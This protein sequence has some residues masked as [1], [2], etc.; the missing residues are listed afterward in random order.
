MWCP[1]ARSI[2]QERRSVFSP[3][4]STHF[5]AL[6][7][8][9]VYDDRGGYAGGDG[10]PVQ[11]GF[12]SA[13]VFGT[14]ADSHKSGGDVLDA[15]DAHDGS[16]LPGGFEPAGVLK[17]VFESTVGVNLQELRD[18]RGEFASLLDAG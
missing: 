6:P 16:E 2:S 3:Y 14:D 11:Q 4:R 8:S 1:A 9:H 12:G 18:A 17:N 15:G 10:K 7:S 13:D 5:Q